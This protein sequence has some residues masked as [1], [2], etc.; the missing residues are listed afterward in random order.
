MPTTRIL[1]IILTIFWLAFLVYW[2]IAA[3][4]S[5]KTI[6]TKT[7]WYSALIRLV[8]FIILFWFLEASPGGPRGSSTANLL[9]WGSVSN[10]ALNITGVILCGAGIAFAIWARTYLGKNWGM[11]MSLKENPELVTSGP[12]ARVRHP[13]YTGVLLAMF[14]TMLVVG[15]IWLILFIFFGIYFIFSAKKEEQIMASQFPDQYAAYKKRT[16]M[17]IPFV[18]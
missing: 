1:G 14:G 7:W 9:A 13:I 8:A 6:R 3:I 11:P 2:L 5:K 15:F 12:Y 10:I 4:S 16:K 18:L 17:L